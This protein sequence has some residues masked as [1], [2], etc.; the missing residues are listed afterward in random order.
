MRVLEFSFPIAPTFSY[1]DLN[2]IYRSEVRYAGL[3]T[4]DEIPTDSYS[5]VRGRGLSRDAV[6]GRVARQ[7]LS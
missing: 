1:P 7:A 5:P 6:V 2:P 4:V 3:P